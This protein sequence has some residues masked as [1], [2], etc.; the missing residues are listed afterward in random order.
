M[1][2]TGVFPWPLLKATV[3]CEHHLETPYAQGLSTLLPAWPESQGWPEVGVFPSTV[4]GQ[5]YN[6]EHLH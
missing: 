2:W 6:L 4:S 3:R 1:P 5:E